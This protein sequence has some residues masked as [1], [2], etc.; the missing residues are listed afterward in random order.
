V[1]PLLRMVRGV[2]PMITETFSLAETYSHYSAN[3]FP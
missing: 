1:S 3:K 2:G